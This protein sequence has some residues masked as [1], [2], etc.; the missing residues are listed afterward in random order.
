M[1]T[2]WHLHWIHSL[3]S[4]IDQHLDNFFFLE[5][6]DLS[7]IESG[8]NF[9]LNKGDTR[10]YSKFSFENV[11]FELNYERVTRANLFPFAN[12]KL[13]CCCC[14]V[15]SVVRFSKTFMHGENK[16]NVTL[17]CWSSFYSL[18]NVISMIILCI[19]NYK[20]LFPVDICTK[21]KKHHEY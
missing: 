17:W 4:S 9:L 5:N 8:R 12:I 13:I 14:F 10:N 19:S 6:V 1:T 18:W 2:L 7:V 3:C 21:W 16:Q 11:V 15:R 20:L